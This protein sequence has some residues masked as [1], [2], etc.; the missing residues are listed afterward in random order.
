MLR[1]VVLS[2]YP[3]YRAHCSARPSTGPC[4]TRR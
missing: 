4:P 3:L 2:G 1:G